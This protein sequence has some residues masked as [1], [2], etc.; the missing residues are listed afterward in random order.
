VAGVDRAGGP[1]SQGSRAADAKTDAMECPTLPR[2]QGPA[3]VWCA[4]RPDAHGP[5][6]AWRVDKLR[7]G[8]TERRSA[9]SKVCVRTHSPCS[10]RKLSPRTPPWATLSR[11]CG[12]CVIAEPNRN[13]TGEGTR[14][15]RPIPSDFA[16]TQT[17]FQTRFTRRLLKP[18]P[19]SM[20]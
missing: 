6:D 18:S 2:R 9:S 10:R 1:H 11:P 19:D 7:C 13:R 8:K 3:L 17:H 12:V 15:I 5:V 16:T 20:E 4:L 14:V